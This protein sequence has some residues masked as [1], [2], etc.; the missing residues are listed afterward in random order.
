M[1]LVPR[2]W[3]GYFYGRLFTLKKQ[4]LRFIHTL[5]QNKLCFYCKTELTK[6]NNTLDHRHP[7][8][9]GGKNSFIN[10]CASC[11]KCN[12]AKADLLEEDFLNDRNTSPQRI[13]A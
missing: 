1:K 2:K 11:Y 12:Q 6:K 13:T 3:K 10:T 8:S 9:K 7:L 5:L 4:L